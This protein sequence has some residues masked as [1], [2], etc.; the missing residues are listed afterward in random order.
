MK[1]ERGQ[2][3]KKREKTRIWEA[4]EQKQELEAEANST[5]RS[6]ESESAPSDLAP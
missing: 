5:R 1:G 2:I 4:L 6:N 3:R